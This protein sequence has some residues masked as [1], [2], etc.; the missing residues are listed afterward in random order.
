MTYLSSNR[1]NS[2]SK[3]DG[4]VLSATPHL[5]KGTVAQMPQSVVGKAYTPTPRSIQSSTLCTVP[6]EPSR[7]TPSAELGGIPEHC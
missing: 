4:E 5:I 6:W 7:V 3:Q 2:F 1:I